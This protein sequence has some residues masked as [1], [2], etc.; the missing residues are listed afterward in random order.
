MGVDPEGGE[1]GPERGEWGYA[2][3][4]GNGVD[5]KGGEGVEAGAGLCQQVEEYDEWAR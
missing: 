2:Y 5:L 4:G 1:G 3:K